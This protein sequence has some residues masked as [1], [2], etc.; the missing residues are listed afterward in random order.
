ML[1]KF[2]NADMKTYP[3]IDRHIGD[4]LHQVYKS[5][6]GGN[7]QLGGKIFKILDSELG[8]K[9]TCSQAKN[10]KKILS[11]IQKSKILH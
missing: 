5:L 4:V 2:E 9:K 1:V 11:A 6:E 10:Y 3:I 8:L 7:D